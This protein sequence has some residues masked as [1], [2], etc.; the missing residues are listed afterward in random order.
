MP[1]R[2]TSPVTARIRHGVR[3][4]LEA[5]AER[6]YVTLSALIARILTEWA[7]GRS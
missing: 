2:S 1:S 4:T 7:E 6:E 3:A 5:A